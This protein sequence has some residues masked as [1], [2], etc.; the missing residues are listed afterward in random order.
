MD[1]H[2]PVMLEETINGLNIKPGGTYVDLTF[3]SGGHAIEILKHIGDGRLMAFD[4]DEDAMQNSIR[5]ER[6]LLINHNFRY[7]KNFLQYYGYPPVDGILADLGVSSHQF[8]TPDRGF[9][10]R[11]DSRLDMRMSSRTTLT[12]STVLN[13]YKQEELFRVFRSYGEIDNALQLARTILQAR[14]KE[15][16]TTMEGFRT[17]IMPCIPRG[18]E[19]KYLAR[20]LQALRIEVNGELEALGDMLRQSAVMLKKGGRLVII[21]YH[22]LEDRLVKNFMRTGNT[23]GS[24]HADIYGH[25]E[26]I[27]KVITRKPL[28]PMEAEMAANP[29]S[30]SAKLRIAEKS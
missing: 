27:F 1:Y 19:N 21:S 16:I 5:D 18:S 12:A 7:M 15:A 26:Q 2:Q 9:S 24:V 11:Y 14:D 20:V 10:M 3:G 22:S 23:E 4:R 17:V 8:D 6:L 29:R 30:R 25:R 28:R 13:I